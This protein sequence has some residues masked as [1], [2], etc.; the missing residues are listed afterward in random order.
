MAEGNS[1]LDEQMHHSLID[2]LLHKDANYRTQGVELTQALGSSTVRQLF[3]AP[4][5][6][7][8]RPRVSFADG[9]I[10]TPEVL[11]VWI[12]EAQSVTPWCNELKELNLAGQMRLT[13]VDMLMP[14]TSLERLDLRSCIRLKKLDGLGS[15]SKLNWLR[16]SSCHQVT[17]LSPLRS[18]HQLKYLDLSSSK[19]IETLDPLE[20]LPN[21]AEINL[22][23]IALEKLS[24]VF[25]GTNKEQRYGPLAV[26]PSLPRLKV[27]HVGRVWGNLQQSV[28]ELRQLK[29]EVY[30]S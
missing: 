24:T 18:C 13:S 17:D 22:T 2:L 5:Y 3:E 29:L 19:K 23:G 8:G 7:G 10:L 25:T 12:G 27:V 9:Y 30:Q 14:L 4:Q 1:M 26:L 21:L 28:D 6:C 15:L 20:D 11:K 16:L